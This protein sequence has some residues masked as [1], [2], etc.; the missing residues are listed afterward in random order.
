MRFQWQCQA[1]CEPR[2]RLQPLPAVSMQPIPVFSPC[3]SAEARVSASSI[4]CPHALANENLSLESV[5]RW[6]RPPMQVLLCS[7]LQTACFTEP[8]KL[9]FCPD[10]SPH[11]GRA[12]PGCGNL[13]SFTVSS[14]GH[15]LCPDSFLSPPFLRPG[16]V[17]IFLTV[18]G[19]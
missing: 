17:E 3:L 19:V 15:R 8:L 18:V 12:F 9:L 16:Y 11:W 14:Q 10:W 1:H 7:V 13:S 4:Q 5:G 6:H 2:A